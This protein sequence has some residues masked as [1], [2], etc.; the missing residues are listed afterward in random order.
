[1][2]HAFISLSWDLSAQIACCLT[3]VLPCIL[4]SA[5]SKRRRRRTCAAY[6]LY[7]SHWDL[8]S[9]DRAPC[10]RVECRLCVDLWEKGICRVEV[11]KDSDFVT[12]SS[13][14]PINDTRRSEMQLQVSVVTHCLTD[15]CAGL[16][17]WM[18]CLSDRHVLVRHR[19]QKAVACSVVS[20]AIIVQW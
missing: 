12:I 18:C 9:H 3:L 2:S 16:S 7:S 14:V 5:S 8:T 11:T 19:Q 17:A 4:C 15:M 10:I 6:D 1:M 20:L 13:V